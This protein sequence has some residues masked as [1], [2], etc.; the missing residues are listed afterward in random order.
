MVPGPHAEPLKGSF[1]GR[2][3]PQVRPDICDFFF[4]LW[5]L[6]SVSFGKN[7]VYLHKCLTLGL[8]N[9]HTDVNSSE[10]KIPGKMMKL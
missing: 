3:R 7:S 4:L 8:R 5:N 1:L 6:H 10:E 9:N 2:Q